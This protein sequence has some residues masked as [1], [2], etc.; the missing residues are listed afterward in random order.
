MIQAN[1]QLA[2]TQ[3]PALIRRPR[4]RTSQSSNLQASLPAL[5]APPPAV[6]SSK[7]QQLNSLLQQ[8]MSDQIT[9]EQYHERRAK[10]LA[11]Q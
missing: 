3:P 7:Q 10:I 9:P 2:A 5:S 1:Q 11:E 8:Y 6:S 4:T